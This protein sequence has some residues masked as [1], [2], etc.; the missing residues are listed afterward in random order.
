MTTSEFNQERKITVSTDQGTFNFNSYAD[1]L[2]SFSDVTN[3][4]Q[5]A[6]AHHGKS[7]ESCVFVA[8]R[9]DN[10]GKIVQNH[11]TTDEADLFAQQLNEYFAI[12]E[13]YNVDEN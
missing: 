3:T 6:V 5:W 12:C 2:G 9:F 8:H 4:E 13:E 7:G 1:M 11:M 10:I